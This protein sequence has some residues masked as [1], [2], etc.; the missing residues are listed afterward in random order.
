MLLKLYNKN[1]NQN[2]IDL[3]IDIL[4][5]GGLIIFPTDTAYAIGCHALKER[6]IEKIC[7]IK[8]L[9]LKNTVS[10]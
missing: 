3:I 2:D 4:N 1:N 5:A 8:G 7:R 10:R 6:P 9:D